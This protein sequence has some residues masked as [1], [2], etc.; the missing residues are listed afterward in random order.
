MPIWKTAVIL[1]NFIYHSELLKLRGISFKNCECTS[2][3][4]LITDKNWFT[5]I[6]SCQIAQWCGNNLEI[7]SCSIDAHAFKLT[8]N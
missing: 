7:P 5:N 4:K 1:F 6:T 8:H 2:T 3:F